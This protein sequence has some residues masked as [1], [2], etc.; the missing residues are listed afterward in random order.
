MN[1]IEQEKE[2]EKYCFLRLHSVDMDAALDTLKILRCY[3]R[4]DVRV[5]LLRDL[6][7]IYSRPFSHNRGHKIPKHILSEKHVPKHL[8]GIH[9]RLLDLRN[10]QFAHT[11]LTFHKPKV[12]RWPTES[13][14]IYPMSF[15]SFDYLGLFRQLSEIEALVREVAASINSEARSY[16]ARF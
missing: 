10:Y 16:E 9:K 13:G 2:F 1:T 14:H 15:K 11:D 5:A 8:K 12:S 4:D 6:A 3:R 7:V